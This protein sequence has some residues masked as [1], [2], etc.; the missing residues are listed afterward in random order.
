MTK[1]LA[2]KIHLKEHLYTFS[3]AQSTPLRNHLDDINSV[4]IDL[5]SLD[6]KLKDEDKAIFGCLIACLL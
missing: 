1:S 3:M 6:V 4:I 2:N 5:E